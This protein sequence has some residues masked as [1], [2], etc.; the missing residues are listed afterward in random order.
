M[1]ELREEIDGIDAELVKFFEK[2]MD[3]SRRIGV[4]KRDHNL[5]IQD[6]ER[7]ET[8]VKQATALVGEDIA[9]ETGMMMRSMMALSRLYQREYLL[10]GDEPLLPPPAPL[11]TD[12]IRCA[13]SGIPGAWSEAAA[14]KLFPNAAFVPVEQFVD[15][16]TAVREG[17]AD[18]GVAPIENSRTGAIGETYDLLRTFGCFIVART[19]IDIKQCLLAAKGASLRDIREVYSHPEGFGQCSRFLNDKSWDL[20][21]A[22]NT[23]VAARKAA[24]AADKKI[25][26]IGSRYAAE[27]YGLE[28]LAPDIMDSANNRTTFVVIASR[29]EYTSESA[30]I[31][32]T[33]SVIHRSGSLLEALLP[34]YAAGINLTRI[35]SRPSSSPDSYRFFAEIAG[36]IS[37]PLVVS[38]LRHV[39][40]ATAY[41]E[42]MG[43]YDMV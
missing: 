9:A 28:V 31:S 30:F 23:A 7:E 37:D 41:M 3:A 2:R 8:V 35:E 27:T 40:A 10:P 18:Y 20:I 22:S 43:C 36:N 19:Q 29:P 32:L 15:I 17:R 39:S 34:F 16:F 5:S 14:A 42:V 11:K 24:G 21:P 33:F 4:Y 12:N 25:A 26:A 13:Y 1:K 38:T 6:L